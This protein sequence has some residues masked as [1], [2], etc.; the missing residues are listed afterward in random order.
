[1]RE[2]VYTDERLI[3]EITEAA[4][5]ARDTAQII[6]DELIKTGVDF[7]KDEIF[8]IWQIQ[9]TPEYIKEKVI[10]KKL[11]AEP[12]VIFGMTL[13]KEKLHDLVEIENMEEITNT[14]I[15][16]PYTYQRSNLN[17]NYGRGL[18][19]I[20]NGVV[21]FVANFE[22]LVFDECTLYATTPEQKL[23]LQKLLAVVE[24]LNALDGVLVEGWRSDVDIRGLHII[25]KKFK[26]NM[27]EIGYMINR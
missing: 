16:V 5:S 27:Q 2:A 25:N 4:E 21:K 8:D 14:Y 20:D 9:A 3:G 10:D 23:M 12:P 22:D 26:P 19:E 11:E 15:G 1:M 17:A 7:T 24:P 18:C 13:S 6:Y